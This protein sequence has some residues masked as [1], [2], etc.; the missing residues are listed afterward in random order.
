MII[1]ERS[2]VFSSSHAT[3]AVD[4]G[5]SADCAARVAVATAMR[6]ALGPSIGVNR[7]TIIDMLWCSRCRDRRHWDTIRRR[8]RAL[9]QRR[10]CRVG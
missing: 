9:M 5:S 3:R 1:L 6:H 2:G 10:D 4:T 7:I 8:T